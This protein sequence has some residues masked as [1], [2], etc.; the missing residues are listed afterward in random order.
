MLSRARTN[1]KGG[2]ITSGRSLDLTYFSQ[3]I[4]SARNAARTPPPRSLPPALA[5]QLSGFPVMVRA[6]D[7]WLARAAVGWNLLKP[8]K[9]TRTGKPQSLSRHLTLQ[10]FVRGSYRRPVS[11]LRW[12]QDARTSGGVGKGR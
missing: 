11:P 8:G 12:P 7:L 6:I 2:S 9:A 10:G 3:A 5:A 4:L 1:M